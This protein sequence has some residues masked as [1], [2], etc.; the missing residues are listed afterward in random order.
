M[1]HGPLFGQ[2]IYVSE[3]VFLMY[4]TDEKACIV[5]LDKVVVKDEMRERM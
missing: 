4:K 1:W 5:F 2:V 3:L